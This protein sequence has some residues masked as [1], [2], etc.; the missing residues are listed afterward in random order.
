VLLLGLCRVGGCAQRAAYAC[1]I[2]CYADGVGDA[3]ACCHIAVGW[4]AGANAHRLVACDLYQDACGQQNADG[5]RDA[6]QHIY[7][8]LYRNACHAERNCPDCHGDPYACYADGYGYRDTHSNGDDRAAHVNLHADRHH[9]T[10]DRYFDVH[11]YAD[12]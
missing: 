3:R 7:T 1:S 6:H 9:S 12:R 10:A 5:Y 11:A 8:D 4:Y 2:Y